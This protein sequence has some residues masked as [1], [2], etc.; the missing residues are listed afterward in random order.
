[1]RNADKDLQ[2]NE[3]RRYKVYVYTNKINGKKYVGQTCRTLT[4]RAGKDGSGYDQCTVFWNAIQ[5]YGWDNFHGEILFD[6]LTHDEANKLEIKLISILKTSSKEYGY[7]ISKGGTGGNN[8]PV[9]PVKQYDY[10][11]NFISEFP[12][13][14]DAA[15]H[16][17]C[18]NGQI[19]YSCKYHGSACGYLFRY[20]WE[21]PPKPKLYEVVNKKSLKRKDIFN[22]KPILQFSLNGELIN[23]YK[24][25]TDIC[26][27][28]D[29][30]KPIL[31]DVLLKYK[32]HT[33]KNYIWMYENEFNEKGGQLYINELIN[34]PTVVNI[35]TPICQFDLN[36]NYITTYP[37]TKDASKITK[38]SDTSIYNVLNGRTKT[39]GNYIWMR[40]SDYLNG[41]YNKNKI[42]D[43]IKP[44]YRTNSIVQLDLNNNF[45]KCY[46][47]LIEA[48]KETNIDR[49][50]IG[51]NCNHRHK[52]A[53][54]FIWM[55][56]K[57]YDELFK[58]AI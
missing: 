37:S 15:R 29:I 48:S 3:D 33:Y 5:K 4:E 56:K 38:I 22:A 21:E 36:M 11:G 2:N 45:I 55:Y 53:G 58:E 23:R 57:E 47:S 19:T 34:S 9:T 28:Y 52:T 32:K 54:G 20:A 26:K 46:D 41:N 35:K 13:A 8:K 25:K 7:N 17:G 18:R 49:T 40:E 6:S 12:S 16:L 14:T 39:A 30:K 1:M 10:N 43:N 44:K 51:N 24:D 50:C 42:V 27:K 31:T